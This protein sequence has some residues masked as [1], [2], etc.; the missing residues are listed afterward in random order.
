M[1][2]VVPT[3][4]ERLGVGTVDGAR[5]SEPTYWAFCG[6]HFVDR[7]KRYFQNP[8]FSACERGTSVCPQNLTLSLSKILCFQ[9]P[10]R[11]LMRFYENDQRW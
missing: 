4:M 7:Q 8:A 11:F 5:T 3:T 10:G 6:R 9:A 2:E 1:L